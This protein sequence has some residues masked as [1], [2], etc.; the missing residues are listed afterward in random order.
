LRTIATGDLRDRIG[1]QIDRG[2]LVAVDPAS[3]AIALQFYEGTLKIV[4]CSGGFKEK[5]YNVL[6]SEFAVRDLAFLS[7]SQNIGVRGGASSASSATSDILP[8]SG[9]S[10]SGSPTLAVLYED[11]SSPGKVCLNCYEL[12]QRQKVSC[13][14]ARAV[15]EHGLLLPTAT[16]Y[17]FFP[18]SSSALVFLAP[19]K[20]SIQSLPYYY[21]SHRPLE[22]ASSS[23]ARQSLMFS[24]RSH[25]RQRGTTTSLFHMQKPAARKASRPSLCLPP[26]C[27]VLHAL[28]TKTDI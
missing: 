11:E 14:A 21:P 8:A 5:A 7:Q 25:Q 24:R 20:G 6:L 23:R 4:P 27:L 12:D 1:R 9:A 26:S 22:A 15:P 16:L 19:F 10:A 17:C 18:C 3:R 13:A 2:Q 28:S